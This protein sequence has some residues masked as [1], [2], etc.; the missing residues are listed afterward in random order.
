M[1]VSEK[2]RA[3]VH[4]NL[5]A[6]SDDLI[7]KDD[8]NFFELGFVDSPFAMQLVCFVEDTFNICVTDED[9]DLLNFSTIARIVQ[10]VKRK[11]L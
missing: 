5:I 3:F 7:L 8:D 2:V 9:L 4:A 11:I 6:F 1:D 10:F